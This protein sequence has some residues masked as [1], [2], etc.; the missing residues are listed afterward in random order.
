DG[1]DA[2]LYPSIL[3]FHKPYHTEGVTYV[4]R[5][6]KL[7]CTKVNVIVTL[8]CEIDKDSNVLSYGVHRRGKYRPLTRELLAEFK[9]CVKKVFAEVAAHDMEMSVL[10]HL[11]AGGKRYD[12]RNNFL[13]DPLAY[14]DD[15]SYQDTLIAA[16][17]EAILKTPNLKAPIDISLSGEMGRSVFAHAD[18]YL[19]IM[20]TLRSDKRLPKTNLGV[21]LNF[22]N[23]A[24]EDTVTAAQRKHAQGLVDECDFIGLSNYRWID[25]PI[26]ATHFEQAKAAFF[27]DMRNSGVTIPSG[28]P[29]HFSEVGIG[30]GTD[31]GLASTPAQAAKTPWNGSDN[32]RKNPW[33]SPQMQ[34]FRRDF[35]RALL[36]FLAQQPQENPVTDAFL[37]SEGSWDPLDT[38]DQGFADPRIIEMIQRHN[39]RVVR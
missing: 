14:Y 8:L 1:R 23:A 11:N 34:Q 15:F 20:R 7:G 38:T 5:A 30:G 36:A 29:L 35:H 32:P 24:G 25:L 37:W 10:A 4:Q 18:S 13:F 31:E 17:Q 27:V 3:L 12:W 21:S 39:Q 2:G 22:S 19:A 33:T 16:I 28:T 6:A 26:D 9:A